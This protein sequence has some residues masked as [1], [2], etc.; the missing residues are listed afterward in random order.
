MSPES[1]TGPK[2][3]E[4][5]QPLNSDQRENPGSYR[6]GRRDNRLPG[7]PKPR[8]PEAT[9]A[10][11]QRAFADGVVES[12]DS[13]VKAR[14]RREQWERQKWLL[15]RYVMED[16]LTLEELKKYAGVTT[17]E[18]TRQLYAAALT[19]VWQKSPQELQLRFPV[20]EVLA[21]KSTARRQTR[22]R[23]E[24]KLK[25]GASLRTS[26]VAIRHRK[27]VLHPS[28]KGRIH[29][30]EARANM[31][32]AHKGKDLTPVHRANIS[33]AMKQKWEMRRATKKD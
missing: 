20:E 2:S 30:A 18:R 17:R 11:V 33:E 32:Q 7:E 31:S 3:Q 25:I 9:R 27:L 21:G 6:S 10:F 15:A 14:R 23:E 16:E 1:Y 24:T 28:L 26:E 29:S 8:L 5:E 12:I 4:S 19:V 13:E 22:I